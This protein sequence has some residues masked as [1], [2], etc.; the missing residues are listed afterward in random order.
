M[1]PDWVY[2]VAVSPDGQ[3]VAAGGLGREGPD[4]GA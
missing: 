1:S 2:A 4:L 3:S